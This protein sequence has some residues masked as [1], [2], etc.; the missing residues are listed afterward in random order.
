MPLR[1]PIASDD[2]LVVSLALQADDTRSVLARRLLRHIREELDC[3]ERLI[4]AQDDSVEVRED[5]DRL[6]AV[7]REMRDMVRS[8]GKERV[9]EGV[10]DG[11]TMVGED[12]VSYPVPPNYASKSKLVEG[13]LLRLLITPD[14]RF[15]FK[16]RGPIERER[17]MGTLIYDE[18]IDQWMVVSNGTKYRVLTAS[19]TYHKGQP[20]DDAVLLVPRGAP[21]TWGAVENIIRRDL[22]EFSE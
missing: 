15:I 5:V 22:S 3:L 13:D 6:L 4:V 12:G 19:V 11:N 17:C 20:N 9:V 21:S 2:G 18:Q 14:G 16:Q 7:D 10:F 8:Y 1:T